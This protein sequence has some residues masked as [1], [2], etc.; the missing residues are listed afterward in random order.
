MCV[1]GEGGERW[2]RVFVMEQE[3]G[4]KGIPL[5]SVMS[6][7][8]WPKYF[9][10]YHCMILYQRKCKNDAYVI[11]ISYTLSSVLITFIFTIRFF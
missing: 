5:R 8:R 10:R 4:G 6:G 1:S 2:G 7:R 3:E 11:N 9:L